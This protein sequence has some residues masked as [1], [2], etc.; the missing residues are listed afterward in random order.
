MPAAVT[1]IRRALD[2]LAEDTPQRAEMLA[3]LGSALL[4]AGRL[5]ES[6][7]ALEEA[8]DTARETGDR[9]SELRAIVERQQVRS[10]I[11]PAGVVEEIGRL[12]AE[13]IPALE[14][15]GDDFGLAKAWR[16]LS[17]AHVFA[18]RW[19]ARA[20]ALE[21]A[22]E[23]ARRA[24]EARAEA[25]TYVGLLADALHYGPTPAEEAIARLRG[26]HGGG[27][28]RPGPPRRRQRI[29]WRPPGHARPVRRGESGVHRVGGA[30]RAPRA[31][32]APRRLLDVGRRDR[33]ARRRRRGGRARAALRLRASSSEWAKAASR[34]VVSALPRRR[35][36]R[37]GPRRGGRRVRAT[38]PRRWPSRRTS[39]PR[40]S[41]ARPA[42]ACCSATATSPRPSGS[43]ARRSSWPSRPTSSRSRRTRHSGLAAVL[44]GSR[45]DARR[46]TALL[47]QAPALY[48][49]KGNLVAAG[50][51]AG[52]LARPGATA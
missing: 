17:D 37:P 15:I 45:P 2:L 8:I 36:P 48:E 29:A 6:S 3:A 26:L 13:V 19:Q 50:W 11:E 42:R 28:R 52:E 33:A 38:R 40:P 18:C 9:R 10:F 39:P 30:A 12:A 23:H 14:E 43:P 44:A 5:E 47:A 27:R 7:F 34:A 31:R 16:L 35:A 41:S 1:L 21:R 22:I 49:R 4:R 51:L 25:S 32:H 46:P 24:P 20:E